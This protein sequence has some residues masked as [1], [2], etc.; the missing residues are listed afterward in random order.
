LDNLSY[1]WNEKSRPINEKR[2]KKN[3]ET[4]EKYQKTPLTL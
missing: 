2:G 1:S 3:K 4:Q